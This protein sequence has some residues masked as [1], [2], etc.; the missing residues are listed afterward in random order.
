ME[1]WEILREINRAMSLKEIA[2]EFYKRNWKL[3][4]KNGRQVLR[5]AM[6]RYSDKFNSRSG[7]YHIL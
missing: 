7:D 1:Q 5:A 6:L 4:E 2:D 3:S